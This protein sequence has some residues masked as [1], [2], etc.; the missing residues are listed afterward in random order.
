MIPSAHMKSL[1]VAIEKS[2]IKTF[3]EFAV[4]GHNDTPIKCKDKYNEEIQKFLNKCTAAGVT[5]V[6]NISSS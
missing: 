6:K 4:G 5:T 3:I 2:P 1:Y